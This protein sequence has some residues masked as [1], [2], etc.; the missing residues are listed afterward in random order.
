MKVTRYRCHIL[1]KN[2]FQIFI[3]LSC[4]IAFG[5]QKPIP[6]DSIHSKRLCVEYPGMT[7]FQTTE[8]AFDESE[9]VFTGHVIEIIRTEKLE[10]ADYDMGEDGKLVPIAYE[11][12][13]DYWYVFKTD[14]IFKGAKKEKIKI[15]ARK[16]SGIPPFF[17]LNKKYL[18]FAK[19]GEVQNYPYVYCQG[20]SG[21][22]E[23]AEKE[24]E[25]LRKLIKK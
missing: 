7:R 16:F 14:S 2:L 21:H 12:T 24:I 17:L 20:N 4:F 25:E 6:I 5:Q 1:I 22:I 18:I 8:E 10:G 19:K 9:I 3:L 23:Y 15:Y 13:F 11:P